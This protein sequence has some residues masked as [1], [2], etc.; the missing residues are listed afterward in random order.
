MFRKKKKKQ[1]SECKNMREQNSFLHT[2]YTSVENLKHVT[3]E[4]T[5]S[6]EEKKGLKDTVEEIPQKNKTERQRDRKLERKDKE[7]RSSIQGHPDQPAHQ[8][9]HVQALGLLGGGQ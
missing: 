2:C 9:P 7:I 1:L 8:S 5:K 6:Q 4:I 3:A